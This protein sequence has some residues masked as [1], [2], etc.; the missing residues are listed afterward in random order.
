MQ[1]DAHAGH[2][3]DQHMGSNVTWRMAAGRATR[4]CTST[5][6]DHH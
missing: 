6:T 1:R 3:H 5:T 4:W 2:T